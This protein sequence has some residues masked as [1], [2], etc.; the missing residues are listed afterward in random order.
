MQKLATFRMYHKT[1][2]KN[3]EKTNIL[4]KVQTILEE[5]KI[6]LITEKTSTP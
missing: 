1:R 2:H 3:F 4:H 6:N 5:R